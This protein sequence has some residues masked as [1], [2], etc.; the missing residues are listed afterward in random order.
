MSET[1]M[2]QGAHIH[3][4]PSH[5]VTDALLL[6]MMYDVLQFLI[7][8]SNLLTVVPRPD[9]L[10]HYVERLPSSSATSLPLPYLLWLLFGIS[11]IFVIVI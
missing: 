9:S 5:V 11:D 8:F 2:D 4:L 7:Q 10:V 3:P 1:N 6:T